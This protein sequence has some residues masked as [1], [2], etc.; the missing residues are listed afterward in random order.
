LGFCGSFFFRIVRPLS[1]CAALPF[2][3]T[4]FIGRITGIC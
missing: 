2:T 1:A 4:V 3:L